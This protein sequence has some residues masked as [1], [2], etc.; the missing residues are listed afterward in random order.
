MLDWRWTTRESQPV[1]TSVSCPDA[2]VRDRGCSTAIVDLTRPCSSQTA[3]GESS[4]LLVFLGK[5]NCD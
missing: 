2:V 4:G 3:T 1:D 5:H